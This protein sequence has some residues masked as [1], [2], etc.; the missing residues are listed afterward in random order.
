MQ[1]PGPPPTSTTQVI[2]VDSPDGC[3]RYAKW[4]CLFLLIMALIPA[5]ILGVGMLASEVADG[6]VEPVTEAPAVEE[7]GK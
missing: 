7:A 5:A 6:S 2:R 3:F 4:G 1:I